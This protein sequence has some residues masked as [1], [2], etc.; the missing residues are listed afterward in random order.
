MVLGGCRLIKE[1]SHPL[2]TTFR[3]ELAH[4]TVSVP[5]CK[6]ERHRGKFALSHNWRGG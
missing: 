1:L 4:G 6:I 5:R 2:A 3:Q